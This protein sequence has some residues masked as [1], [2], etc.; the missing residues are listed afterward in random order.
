MSN[1]VT[2]QLRGFYA[3]YMHKQ[4]NPAG[5]KG[6]AGKT[7][8]VSADTFKALFN[9]LREGGEGFAEGWSEKS[10]DFK[11]LKDRALEAGKYYG[12]VALHYAPGAGAGALAGG[13]GSIAYDAGQGEG[14]NVPRAL[15]MAALGGA[16]GV[17]IQKLIE[18]LRAR[19]AGK[20]EDIATV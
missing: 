14:I 2:P 11:G 6:L 4:A 19:K 20:G 1:Q 9:A 12:D 13:G 15:M 3:G 7:M 10:P 8:E 18:V 5:K 17:G 16:G